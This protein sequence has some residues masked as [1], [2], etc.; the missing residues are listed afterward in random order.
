[1]KTQTNEAHEK[2]YLLKKYAEVERKISQKRNLHNTEQFEGYLKENPEMT[3]KFAIREIEN[4]IINCDPF[5]SAAELERRIQMIESR[6]IEV[7]EDPDNEGYDLDNLVYLNGYLYNSKVDFTQMKK[8]EEQ[9]LKGI[10]PFSEGV[11]DSQL[12]PF[13]KRQLKK[14]KKEEN[15]ENSPLLNFPKLDWRPQEKGKLAELIHAL[16]KS[17]YISQNGKAIKGKD[18]VKVFELLFSIKFSNFSATISDTFEAPRI[19][20]SGQYFTIEL[21]NLLQESFKKREGIPKT[22]R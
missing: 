2:R 6:M 15:G 11:R 14:L 12:L 3:G 22:K 20:K 18:L 13:L 16:A 9:F 1:M 4:I 10:I 19:S 17:E 5:H 7:Y 8:S 21:T